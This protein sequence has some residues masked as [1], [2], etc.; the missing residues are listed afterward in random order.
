MSEPSEILKVATEPSTSD[1][2]F[3][4]IEALVVLA[5]SSLLLVVLTD[6]L[7]A[8]QRGHLRLEDH[9][10][11]RGEAFYLDLQMQA[12]ID[13]VYVDPL[14]S[15]SGWQPALNDRRAPLMTS[16]QWRQQQRD[17]VFQG[18]EATVTGEVRNILDG[19]GAVE[20]FQLN[21]VDSQSGRQ[22]RLLVG[23]MDVTWPRHFP[24]GTVFRFATDSGRLVEQWPVT[25]SPRSD[26]V[27]EVS[28]SP[29][30]PNAIH[31]FDKSRSMT[32]A[33]YDVPK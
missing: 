9:F 30:L 21:W 33:V 28:A 14:L 22:I 12:L 2:G 5:I 15:Q 4:L 24:R 17:P 3:S 27:N 11:R 1:A 8:S 32:L 16:A 20:P 19:R 18:S 26:R 31:L 7:V 25:Q 29:T 23:D 13:H 10:E 6:T